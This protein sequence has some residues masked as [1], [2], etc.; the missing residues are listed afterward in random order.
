MYSH[1]SEITVNA[2]INWENKTAVTL[3]Q[4]D[5]HDQL[6]K[7]L[8]NSLV[9][10]VQK[11]SS[12]FSW[13]NNYWTWP[14]SSTTSSYFNLL[15]GKMVH[16]K[17]RI[18]IGFRSGSNVAIWTS[19]MD[20]SEII[21]ARLLLQYT[22]QKQIISFYKRYICLDVWRIISVWL[23]L[24]RSKNANTFSFGVCVIRELMH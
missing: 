7:I 15:Y 3:K 12:C 1:V 8:W 24:E 5:R 22:T 20:C 10:S 18:L 14:V 11:I 23:S 16:A 21:S 13:Y 2:D 17:R 19:R 6:Y 4:L 9:R